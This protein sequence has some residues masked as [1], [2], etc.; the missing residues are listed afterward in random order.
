MSLNCFYSYLLHLFFGTPEDKN[1]LPIKK[2][3]NLSQFEKKVLRL[4][5][6]ISFFHFKKSRLRQ[7]N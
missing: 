4:K 2:I 1:L 7:K 5:N 6:I 3:K